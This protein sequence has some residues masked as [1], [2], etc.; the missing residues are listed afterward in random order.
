[1]SSSRPFRFGL[2]VRP[3]ASKDEWATKARPLPMKDVS[4]KLLRAS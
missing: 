1:M 4:E 3:T 2:E